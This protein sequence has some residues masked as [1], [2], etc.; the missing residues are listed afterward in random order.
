MHR[1]RTTG[2]LLA[3][4]LATAL[5]VAAQAQAKPAST[6]SNVSGER[7]EPAGVKGYVTWTD[8]ASGKKHLVS[9]MA[10]GER[11]LWNVS[12]Y[13][14]EGPTLQLRF[15][16]VSAGELTQVVVSYSHE[17]YTLDAT[18]RRMYYQTFNPAQAETVPITNMPGSTAPQPAVF[19]YDIHFVHDLS[20]VGVPLQEPHVVRTTRAGQMEAGQMEAE[21]SYVHNIRYNPTRHHFLDIAVKTP[22]F[23]GGR[24]AVD[25]NDFLTRP[26]S[27]PQRPAPFTDLPA[28]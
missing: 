18:G 10:Q 14:D 1:T 22:T 2:T 16:G 27:Q 17:T 19:R 20:W 15:K 21:S 24:I 8:P 9:G 25:L 3:L 28:F 4:L 12:F 6:L 5:P 7:P 13:A 11:G 23:Q 26:P